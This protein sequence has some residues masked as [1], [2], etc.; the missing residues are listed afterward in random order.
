MNERVA[1]QK[2]RSVLGVKIRVKIEVIQMKLF[3]G[4]SKKIGLVSTAL[5]GSLF[6][7]NLSVEALTEQ[8]IIQKLG[9]VPVFTITNEQGALI[10]LSISQE[11]NQRIPVAGAF[12]SM[13]DAQKFIEQ[14]INKGNS[15]LTAQV[16][17]VSIADIYQLD[18]DNQNNPEGVDFVFVP[19]QQQVES[20][21]DLLRQRGHQVEQFPDVPLFYATAGENPSY[22]TTQQNGQPIVPLFF[23]KAQLQQQVVDRY[24]EANPEIAPTVKIQVLSLGRLIELWKTQDDPALNQFVLWP[25][26]ESLDLLQRLSSSRQNTPQ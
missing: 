3:M 14:R 7:G 18:Q 21:M 2:N 8:Q 11:D 5:L 1:P 26:P 10:T 17:V 20:A 9:T 23:D 22:I 6:I 19:V 13:E 12:I 25:S 24:K 15:G 4:W 16:A